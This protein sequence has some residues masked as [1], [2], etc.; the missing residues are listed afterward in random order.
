VRECIA[1][2]IVLNRTSLSHIHIY[3]EIGLH[4]LHFLHLAMGTKGVIDYILGAAACGR[5]T[6]RLLFDCLKYLHQNIGNWGGGSNSDA[7]HLIMTVSS[8]LF[9]SFMS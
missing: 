8:Y 3:D 9:S 4:S 7:Y 1:N 6:Q 5:K 2:D